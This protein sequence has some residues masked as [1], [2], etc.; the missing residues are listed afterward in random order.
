MWWMLNAQMIEG[1]YRSAERTDI[2]WVIFGEHT[3][4]NFIKRRSCGAKSK[5]SRIGRVAGTS[6]IDE[7]PEEH[8]WPVVFRMALI[9]RP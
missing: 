9:C 6:S 4:A 7:L 1:R 2:D 5:G 8:P 3:R